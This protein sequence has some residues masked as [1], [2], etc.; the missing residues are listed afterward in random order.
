MLDSGEV[1]DRTLYTFAVLERLQQSLDRREIFVSP[2][3]RWGDPRAKLLPAATWTSLRGQI[4][5]TLGRVTEP[6]AELALLGQQLDAAYLDTATNLPTNTAVRLER[7]AGHDRPIV[8][9]LDKLDEPLTLKQVRKETQGLVPRVELPELLLE[10]HAMTGFAD[11]FTHMSEGGSRV[12]DLTLS[13]CAVLVAEAC[14]IGLEP[15]VQPTIPALTRDRLAWVQQNYL[16][17][18]TLTRANARLL[19][20]QAKIPIAQAWGGGEVASADGLRFV[21]PVRTINAGGSPK[22]FPRERGLTWYNGIS[23]QNMGFNALV[24]P[25]ALRDAP[26]LLNLLLEQQT[27]LQPVEVMTDTA[28]YSDTVFGLFWLL[29]YQFSPRLADLKDMRFWRLDPKANYGVLNDVGRQRFRARWSWST[30]MSF[31]GWRGR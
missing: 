8:T 10:I 14:N 31:C 19:A 13:I 26:Y 15:L 2:N 5:R 16:R 22:H 24:I 7:I 30:G 23:D 27:H 6:Q 21:V 18:E 20:A 17:T 25:G 29:G 12:A 1:V 11:A 28:G 3:E 9:A 4:C